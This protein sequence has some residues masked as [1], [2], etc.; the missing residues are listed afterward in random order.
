MKR[1]RVDFEQRCQGL[2]ARII[3]CLLT[4]FLLAGCASIPIP[5]REAGACYRPTNVYRESRLLPVGIKRVA[6]LPMTTAGSAA[7]LTAGAEALEPI[8]YAELEKSKRFEVIAVS[9]A[10]LRQWTGQTGWNADEQLPS[11]LFERLR[12]ATGCDAV[13]F[14]QLTRYQP[15]QTLSIGWKLSLTEKAA[16]Q[17]G[18][19][20]PAKDAGAHILW[21]A[22]EVFDAGNPEVANAARSYYGQHLRDESPLADASTM[23]SSPGR[24]GQYSLGALLATLPERQNH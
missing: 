16:A 9:G 13:L 10:Q 15:Y 8:L 19:K 3:S 22:D 5:G 14:S 17:N 12:E 6:L 4:T 23:L 18:G 7:L 11:D 20:T 1:A 24:F 2:P 21:S